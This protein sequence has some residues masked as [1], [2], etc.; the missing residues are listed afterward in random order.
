MR[1]DQNA[2]G[3][4]FG[5]HTRGARAR[6]QPA[7]TSITASTAAA[8]ASSLKPLRLRVSLPNMFLR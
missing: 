7:V 5:P 4:S 1:H 6:R 2:T 3:T 8:A